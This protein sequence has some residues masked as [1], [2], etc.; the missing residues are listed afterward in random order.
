LIDIF[1]N[2]EPRIGENCFIAPGSAVI[3]D[4]VIGENASIWHNAVIRGDMARITIG[5]NTNIQDCSVVHC[6]IGIETLI[7]DNVTVGHGAIIHSCEIGNNCLIGMGAVILDGAKIGSNCLIGAG[8]VI[9]PNTVIPDGQ[10]VVGSPG[11]VKRQLSEQEIE[12]MHTNAQ[13][14]LE[15]ICSYKG[16]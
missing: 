9:T 4:V 2:F 12:G 3:G 5:R 6:S 13:H 16:K 7:G 15:L 11:K 8:A 10:L 14:Y 1:N